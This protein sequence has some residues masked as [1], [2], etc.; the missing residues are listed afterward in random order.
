MSRVPV[1]RDINHNEPSGSQEPTIKCIED[2]IK[3]KKENLENEFGSLSKERNNLNNNI[4][5][6]YEE[7]QNSSYAS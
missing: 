3:I 7:F 2:P 1:L 4:S 6:G 5:L